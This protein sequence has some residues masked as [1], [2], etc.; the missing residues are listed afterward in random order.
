MFLSF[1]LSLSLKH[2]IPQYKIPVAVSLRAA[3]TLLKILKSKNKNVNT[4]FT[5]ISRHRGAQSLLQ[6][7]KIE[8]TDYY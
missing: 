8:K 6:K 5:H 4:Q 1:I 7:G 2:I 3:R